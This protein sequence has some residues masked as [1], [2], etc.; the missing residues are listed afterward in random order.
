MRTDLPVESRIARFQRLQMF[1]GRSTLFF[2]FFRIYDLHILILDNC[3]F[4][5]LASATPPTSSTVSAH[6]T[7]TRSAST[8]R[9]TTRIGPSVRTNTASLIRSPR[10]TGRSSSR[11]KLRLPC[12]KSTVSSC[13]SLP[14]APRCRNSRAT[15]TRISARTGWGR[16]EVGYQSRDEY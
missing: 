14:V 11:R 4:S 9:A 15:G 16:G 2:I 3:I 10:R 7:T 6:P 1:R 5:R 13:P 12:S 8:S